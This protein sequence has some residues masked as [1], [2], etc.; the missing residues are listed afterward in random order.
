MQLGLAHVCLIKKEMTVLRAKV[1]ISVPKKRSGR[2]G[3]DKAVERFYA[4]TLKALIKHVDFTVVKAV[5][6][7][8]PGFVK[9]NL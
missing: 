6:L 1:E 8:S 3:H 4:A 2:T 9:V 7:A 5:I